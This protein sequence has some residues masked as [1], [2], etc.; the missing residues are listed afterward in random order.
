[1]LQRDV[2]EETNPACCVQDSQR[3]DTSHRAWR[4]HVLE[5]MGVLLFH[6]NLR[7]TSREC[8]PRERMT[9]ILVCLEFRDAERPTGAE[10]VSFRETILQVVEKP[11]RSLPT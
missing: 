5:P 1:M 11:F 4:V 6:C 3:A 10:K 7:V 9:G 2:H 8:H